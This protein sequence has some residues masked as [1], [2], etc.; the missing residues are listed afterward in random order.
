MQTDTT[1]PHPVFELALKALGKTKDVMML[2]PAGRERLQTALDNLAGTEELKPAVQSLAMLA[3]VLDKQGAG[4]ASRTLL[5]L[6]EEVLSR[7]PKKKG[8]LYGV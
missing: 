6:T 7:P 3:Y 4:A 5:Q 1:N 2:Q 8:N